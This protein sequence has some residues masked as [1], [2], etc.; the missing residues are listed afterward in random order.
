MKKI[1]KYILPKTIKQIIINY[2]NRPIYNHFN[3]KYEKK[4]LL[5][6]ITV[7]FRKDSLNHTNNYEALS[8]ANIL[9]ELGYQVDIIKYDRCSNINLLKYSLICGFGDIFQEY[10]ESGYKDIKT[11]FYATGMH[12]CHQNNTS[13]IRV[14]DV[15]DKKQIYLAKSAR[16]VS[17]T[18]THQTTLVDGIVALGN[19][20]CADSYR[21]YYDGNIYSIP[22][23]F[24]KTV[25]RSIFLQ[26]DKKANTSFLWFGSSGLIH[27]GLDLLLEYF[28]KHPNLTLHI[29]GNIDTEPAFTSIYFKELYKTK[30]IL[31]HG[32]VD[33]KSELFHK[34]IET[35]SFTVFPS[36]SEGGAPSVLTTIGNGGLIPIITKDTTIST[37]NE[38]WIES[39]DY[40]GI[41]KAI[42]NALKLSEIEI[43]ELQSKNYDYVNYNNSKINYYDKLKNSV[44]DII[45]G[46]I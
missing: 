7:P 29:C 28:S 19:H 14:K 45:K 5:S 11:I 9:N 33:I 1:I 2:L 17:K 35:C 3:T 23:P 18:W 32:F 15:F 30:N 13:L 25:K 40:N 37:N 24:F 26:K 6:Y 16:F 42:Q 27:K 34:L 38:I 44:I 41:N 43:F 10:F 31:V 22:A 21:K 39:L 36:C 20:V 46:D 8:W 12:V 4:A